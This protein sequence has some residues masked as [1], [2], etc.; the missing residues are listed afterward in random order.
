MGA[1]VVGLV[2]QPD[3][4][5]D[6]GD[7]GQEGHEVEDCCYV[8]AHSHGSEEGVEL[9]ARVIDEDLVGVQ[10]KVAGALLLQ[11][12]AIAFDFQPIKIKCLGN[13]FLTKDIFFTTFYRQISTQRPN[14]ILPYGSDPSGIHFTQ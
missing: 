4:R 5:G 10:S 12:K 6:D 8:V 11:T 13:F 7:G 3:A 14:T 2:G 9:R 1:L